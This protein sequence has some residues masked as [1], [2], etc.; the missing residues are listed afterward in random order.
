MPFL[1][2]DTVLPCLRH[3]ARTV[4]IFKTNEA[5]SVSCHST[6]LRRGGY[7]WVP[8]QSRGELGWRGCQASEPV[9]ADH[10][11]NLYAS[12]ITSTSSKSGIN[13]IHWKS[14]RGEMMCYIPSIQWSWCQV[15]IRLINSTRS[16]V[17][18]KIL[19]YHR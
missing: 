16:R 14:S 13:T 8:N 9:A 3:G 15:I 7:P 6:E 4:S 2:N 5:G 19:T 17:D 11:N 1:K 12:L 18:I 10:L